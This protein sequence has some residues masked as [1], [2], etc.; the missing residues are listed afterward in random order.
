MVHHP[1]A[2][3]KAQQEIDAIVGQG[4]LPTFA[5]RASLPYGMYSPKHTELEDIRLQ[6]SK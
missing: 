3:R 1:E 6:L 2:Q 5:D 4:R